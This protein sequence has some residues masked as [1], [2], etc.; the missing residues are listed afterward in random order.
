[1]IEP[2]SVLTLSLQAL[3]EEAKLRRTQANKQFA[4]DVKFRQMQ[5]K[6]IKKIRHQEKKMKIEK[7]EREKRV[8][9]ELDLLKKLKR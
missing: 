8:A 6:K 5:Q 3:N 1:M 4:K 9:L 2:N 7:Q